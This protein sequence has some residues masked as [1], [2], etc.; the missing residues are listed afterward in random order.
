MPS[1][2]KGTDVECPHRVG[3]DPTLTYG[4]SGWYGAPLSVR[5]ACRRCGVEV[6][7]DARPEPTEGGG[8]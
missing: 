3:W 6:D 2:E 1:D 7:Y 5:L 8:S 4:A